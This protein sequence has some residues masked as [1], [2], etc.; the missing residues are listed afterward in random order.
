M[1]KSALAKRE[2]SLKGRI[3]K[4]QEKS[5]KA[6]E[7]AIGTAA[8]MGSAFAVS[9]IEGRYPD[10]KDIFGV[11]VSLAVGVSATIA[12]VLGAG[13]DKTANAVLTSAGNGALAAYAAGRGLE[14]GR[15]AQE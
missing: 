4:Y 5:Q 10:K 2:A 14:M 11:P 1:A 15:E 13:G 3:K 7:A 9:Y 8:T 12:G 6:T